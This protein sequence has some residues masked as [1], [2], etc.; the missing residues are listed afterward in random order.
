MAEHSEAV[1]W[2]RVVR[3]NNLPWPYN[4]KTRLLVPDIIYCRPD[5]SVKFGHSITNVIEFESETSTAV[6]AD[7]VARFNES[8]RRMV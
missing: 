6:V 8:S 5:D 1:N 3:M 2:K 4:W 7:K